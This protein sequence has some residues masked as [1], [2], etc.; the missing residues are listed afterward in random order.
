LSHSAL[1]AKLTGLEQKLTELAAEK[2]KL[3]KSIKET[4]TALAAVRPSQ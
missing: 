1:K 2:R 4:N 3:D